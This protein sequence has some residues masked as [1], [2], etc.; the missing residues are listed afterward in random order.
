MHCNI[1]SKTLIKSS[2]ILLGVNS[3]QF[4]TRTHS[5]SAFL[6]TTP[7]LSTHLFTFSF[8]HASSDVLFVVIVN[9]VIFVLFFI[10]YI[11]NTLSFRKFKVIC[12][13]ILLKRDGMLSS[14][15]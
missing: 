11:L 10:P 1:V 12:I 3:R 6:L 7:T 2:R 8:I 9:E 13:Q 15:G 14:R 5:L 4:W